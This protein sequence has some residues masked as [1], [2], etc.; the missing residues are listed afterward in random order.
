MMVL[1]IW[2]TSLAEYGLSADGSRKRQK[3][4]HMRGVGGPSDMHQDLLGGA[5]TGD[6]RYDWDVFVIKHVHVIEYSFI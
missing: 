2:A 4:Y 3:H 1:L 6:S 5:H